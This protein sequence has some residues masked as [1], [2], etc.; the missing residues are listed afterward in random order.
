MESAAERGG[1]ASEDVMACDMALLD[2]GDA[3]LGD[4]H[5]VGDVLLGESAGASY[6][7]EAV[8]DEFV[9]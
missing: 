4:S 9:E 1:E 8:A 2:L 3:S 6:L 5:S 7:G